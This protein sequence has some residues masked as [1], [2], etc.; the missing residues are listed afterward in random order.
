MARVQSAQTMPG[1]LALS[2][3]IGVGR[4]IGDILL[5]ALCCA[6]E[7]IKEKVLFIPL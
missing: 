7:D 2:E 3:N 4:V 6:P 1:V 5:V